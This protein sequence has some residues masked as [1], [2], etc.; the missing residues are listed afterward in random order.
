MNDAVLLLVSA[1]LINHLATNT[2]ATDRHGLGLFCALYV[3]LG[4]SSGYLLDAWLLTPWH[5]QD[6]RL[7]I[8]L[9][10]LALLGW[11]IP[12]ALTRLGLAWGDRSA[13]QP[14]AINVLVLGLILQLGENTGSWLTTLGCAVLGG[15][16]LWLALVLFDDLRQR[17]R[18]DDVPTCL[19]GL[20]IELLGVGVM[21]MAFSG[22]SGLLRP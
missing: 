4:V 22:L 1:V 17:T 19:R 10:W 8:L 13:Q 2:C 15:L 5:L 21:T 18:H 11:T 12:H 6:L 9:P 3:A 16:G 14:L 20:P 7:F